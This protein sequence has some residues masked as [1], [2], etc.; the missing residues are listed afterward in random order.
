MRIHGHALR[1]RV[2]GAARAVAVADPPGRRR[3]IARGVGVPWRR[4]A[5]PRP[6]PDAL[7]RAAAAGADV[8]VAAAALCR[9]VL[10]CEARLMATY[11]ATSIDL[12]PIPG[13]HDGTG[14]HSDTKWVVVP[15]SVPGTGPIE[16]V[17]E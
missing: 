17:G 15:S 16:F 10:R 4:P 11:T 1:R 13:I 2:A 14:V 8:D 3:R 7:S 5:V 9:R 6:L 12:A